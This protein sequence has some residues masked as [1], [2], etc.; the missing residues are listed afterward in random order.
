MPKRLTCIYA[1]ESKDCAAAALATI[2]QFYGLHVTLM[3]L[4]SALGADL[5]GADLF[6]LRRAAEELGFSASS[7]K[8]KP[9]ALDQIPLPAIAHLEQGSSGHFVVI[10]KITTK[11]VIIADP[12]RGIVR[13]RRGDFM[14]QW[15]HHLVLLAPSSGFRTNAAFES[16]LISLLRIALREKKTLLSSVLL[17]LLIMIFGMGVAYAFRLVLDRV[18][19][20]SNNRLLDVV[21]IGAIVV[22]VFY[23]ICGFIRS[24]L[25]A[26]AGL[27]LELK[28]GLH[29]MRHVLYLPIAFFDRQATGEVFA[30]LSDITH[31]RTAITGSLLSGFFDVVLLMLSAGFLLWYAERLALVILCFLPLLVVPMVISARP[32]FRKQLEIREHLTELTKSFI[33]AVANVRVIK[34]F[35][36]E[37]RSH[38]NL[39]RQYKRVQESTLRGAIWS[40]MIG[41][42]TA[43]LTGAVSVAL[44]FVGAKNIMNNH[45]TVGQLMFF[46]AVLGLFLSSVSGLG[47]SLV[48]IQE[49]LVG[50]GRINEISLLDGEDAIPEGQDPMRG[51]PLKGRI[52]LRR[53]SFAYRRGYPVLSNIDLEIPAGETVALIGATGSGKSTLVSLITGFYKPTHGCI[54][55]DGQDIRNISPRSLRR[56]IGVVFQDPGLFS[57]TIREN[58]AF[59]DPGAPFERIREAARAAKADD[60]ITALP[61]DYDYFI[62]VQG[63]ALSAGQRQR[64]AIARALLRSPAVLILD[65]ATGNLDSE[66][67]RGIMEGICCNY[68]GIRTTIIITHRL[69]TTRWA[70]R[71]FVMGNGHIVE[72]GTHEELMRMGGKYCSMWAALSQVDE[73]L[74]ERMQ[75]DAQRL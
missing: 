25:L 47:P 20:H 9:G 38:A 51:T 35:T 71:A 52:A 36:G 24:Y 54:L 59:G 29:Y 67:E 4:R 48:S 28:L 32:L 66:T 7:G 16:S 22:L 21:T 63:A 73:H 5:Q 50:T 46:Y 12:T 58:I 8:A 33:E 56:S 49:A 1:H 74:S 75:R 53:V 37:Q 57:G 26:S 42:S 68:S 14:R 72:A 40:G 15:T 19:P 39:E 70:T 23:A 41:T 62:G 64:V 13:L 60:F 3:S 2:A 11:K 27:R 55:L 44:L 34:A 30:R 6:S 17:A 31:V 10:H 18:I 61:R 69:F 43:F 65:E 45:L